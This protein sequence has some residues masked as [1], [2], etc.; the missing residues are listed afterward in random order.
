MADNAASRGARP[1][2]LSPHL[3]IYRWPSTM[4]TSIIH[5]ATGMILTAAMAGLAWWLMALATGPDAYAGFTGFVAT[6]LGQF[7]IF[8]SIWALSYHLL[9]GIRHLA[10]DIG[11]GFQ[12]H[13]ANLVSVLIVAGSVVLAVIVY[14]IGLNAMGMLS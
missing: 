9:N 7:L 11:Y 13:T 6:P 1:R 8:V 14:F 12:P 2:P 3:Q 4:A 10:W 5:R